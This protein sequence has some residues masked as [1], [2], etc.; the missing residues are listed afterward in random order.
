MNLLL[1]WSLGQRRT[2]L[3]LR[4]LDETNSVAKCGQMLWELVHLKNGLLEVVHLMQK[5][6]PQGMFL[7]ELIE[8]VTVT[9]YCLGCLPCKREIASYKDVLASLGYI[10]I[11][12]NPAW[13]KEVIFH[14]C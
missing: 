8:D 12:K 13:G 11:V 1:E 10:C 4:K 6:N 9:G 7:F 14:S 3:A 2:A 5:Q